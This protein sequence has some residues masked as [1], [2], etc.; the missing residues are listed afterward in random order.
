MTYLAM[1][2]AGI[3]SCFMSLARMRLVLLRRLW[4]PILDT[5]DNTIP[6]FRRSYALV[7]SDTGRYALSCF[8]TDTGAPHR[9]FN[10]V[11]SKLFL[12]A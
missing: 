9:I 5:T 6:D 4:L 3:V 8:L 12:K 7:V 10:L 2:F 1:I 11:R